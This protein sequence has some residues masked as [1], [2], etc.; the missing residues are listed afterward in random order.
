[1]R[2]LLL[3]L[4]LILLG[5]CSSVPRGYENLHNQFDYD[6][7]FIRAVN[8]SN[9]DAIEY[10]LPKVD[11]NMSVVLDGSPVIIAIKNEDL[12]VT[13]RLIKAGASID[14][15]DGNGDYPIHIATR[16]TSLSIIDTLLKLKVNAHK[17][18]VDGNTALHLIIMSQEKQQIR[19]QIAKKLLPHSNTQIT[20]NDNLRPFDLAKQLQQTEILSLLGE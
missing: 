18:D 1:M 2:I 11:V 10:L 5:S 7:A 20:N 13:K 9:L 3:L 19:Q 14:V 12:A 16:N 17:Q 15:P 8:D 6:N 4:S